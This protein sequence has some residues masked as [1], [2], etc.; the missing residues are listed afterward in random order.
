MEQCSRLKYISCIS[1]GIWTFQYEDTNRKFS[2]HLIMWGYM[3]CLTKSLKY[4]KCI[5][6]IVLKRTRASRS[7]LQTAVKD[8]WSGS[9]YIHHCVHLPNI[10]THVMSERQVTCILL[11]PKILHP[12]IT[13]RNEM[14]SKVAT[15]E[16]ST[17][18]LCLPKQVS[19]IVWAISTPAKSEKRLGQ[20]QNSKWN[21][22]IILYSAAFSCSDPMKSIL[23]SKAYLTL[24]TM[25][26]VQ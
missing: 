9:M 24:P 21:H 23:H 2:R 17:P 13:Q 8:S 26:L 7:V 25:Q 20:Q 6:P 12:K 16:R 22:W 3:I 5:I 18:C 10:K 1:P 4:F 14:Y 15:E 11:K 19:G